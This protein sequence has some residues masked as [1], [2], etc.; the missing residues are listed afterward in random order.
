MSGEIKV[1]FELVNN[2]AG[3]SIS[4][5]LGPDLQQEYGPYLLTEVADVDA[6]VGYVS[7][8]V[9]AAGLAFLAKTGAEIC[10][11]KA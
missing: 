4:V 2:L 7:R 10:E 11:E 5:D 6:L 9:R 3:V 8:E 1:E